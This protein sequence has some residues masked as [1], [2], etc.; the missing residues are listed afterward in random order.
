MTPAARLAAAAGVLDSILTGIRAET[1]LSTWARG[2][3]YAGSKDRTA[4]RD[5]VFA[6]LRCKRSYARLGGA[7]SGRGLMIGHLRALGEDP[8]SLLTGP[9]YGLPPLLPSEGQGSLEGAPLDER[10]D[11]PAWLLPLFESALGDQTELALTALQRRAPVFLRVNLAKTSRA[12]AIGLLARDDITA[13]AHPAV[14]TAVAVVENE[15]RVKLSAAFDQGL[16]E[17]QDASSQA[18][19]LELP[20]ERGQRVLDYCAGGGGKTLAMAGCADLRIWAHDAA[21]RRMADLPVRARR[22]GISVAMVETEALERTVPFDLVLVDA[23]CSGSGTWRRDPEGK[24]ALT[25]ERLSEL[26]ALQSRILD[27][28]VACVREGGVLAYMTCSVLEAENQV[29]IEGFMARHSLWRFESSHE[30]VP[31]P[32]GDGFYLCV[33][34]HTG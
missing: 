23:P 20:L 6:A 9:P 33:L 32:A 19:V 8:D 16:V 2:S 24:W 14:E 27:T 4:V 12:E 5:L 26:V 21:P 28:A 18:A 22:A 13:V 7:V 3:R 15:R 17:P 25:S 34:R 11:L 29:Q 31:G 10:C 1:A 30:W